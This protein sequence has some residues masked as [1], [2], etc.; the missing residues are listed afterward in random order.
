MNT[1]IV[2]HQNNVSHAERR[3]LL[4]QKPMVV[5]FTGLSGSG[6]STIAA[7]V[8][9]RLINAGYAAYLLDGDNVRHGLNNNLGFDE[10]DRTE[11]IRRIYETAKLFSDSGMIVL[12]SAISPLRKMRGDARNCIGGDF[13]EIYVEAD[14]QTCIA[15]DPKGLYKRALNGEIKNFTGINAPYEIPENPEIILDTVNY[16]LD[17]SVDLVYNYILNTQIDYNKLFEILLPAA[18]KAGEAI[19]DIYNRGFSV[20]YKDDKSPLTEADKASNA[21][22]CEELQKHFPYYSVLTEE[23]ADDISR[24]RERYCFIV[25]PLDGTK[26]FI[27]RNGEF[28]VNIAL[29]FDGEPILGIIY[30]PCTDTLYYARKNGG[31]YKNGVKIH[32]SD[33]TDDLILMESRSHGDSRGAELVEK[34]KSRIADIISAGS[35][36]KGCLIAEGEAD[37]YYRFGYTMEWDTAA[38]QCICEEAGAIFMQGDDTPMFYNRRNSLN[39]KGFYILNRIENKLH[40]TP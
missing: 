15:R 34:N 2:W 29:V 3:H 19:M 6:K 36:L 26:E 32:V 31:A 23:S 38:M 40:G 11:N 24:L 12:V 1:N 9:R 30:V 14:L 5:W 20:E 21:I 17:Y 33:R 13:V 27:K 39:E 25:D 16:P 28:T 22:I 8:E 7:E 10:K 4:G 37:V 35:S 18:I